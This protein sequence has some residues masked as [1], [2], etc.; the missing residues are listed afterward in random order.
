[1]GPFYF[2]VYKMKVILVNK[3]NQ[4]ITVQKFQYIESVGENHCYW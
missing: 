4:I 2:V 3:P 1:M